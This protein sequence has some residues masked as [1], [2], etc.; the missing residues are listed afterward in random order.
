MLNSNIKPILLEIIE[1]IENNKI[2]SKKAPVQ[3]TMA[4]IKKELGKR[5]KTAIN[6]LVSEKKI[7][8]GQTLNDIYFKT[9]KK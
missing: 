6:E 5:V 7:V 2:G 1:E 3:A 4:E 9:T 8:F